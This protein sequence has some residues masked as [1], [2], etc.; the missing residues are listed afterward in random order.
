[1]MKELKIVRISANKILMIRKKGV[2]KLMERL[3][4]EKKTIC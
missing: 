1:M 2:T 4:K 3:K